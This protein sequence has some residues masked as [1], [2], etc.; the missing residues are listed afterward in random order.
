MA[1]EHPHR[2]RVMAIGLTLIVFSS[3]GSLVFFRTPRVLLT[4]DGKL[5]M[6]HPKAKT[7][8]ELLKEASVKLGP[9]DFVTPTAETALKRNLP[10]KVTRVLSRV[11][12]VEEP[13]PPRVRWSQRTRQ[14]LRRVLV[15]R[16]ETPIRVKKVRVKLHDG[17]EVSRET[18]SQTLK[19]R[20]FYTLSLFNDR[21][22]QIKTYDLL[23]AKTKTF[24]ATGYYVGD[25]MV[26][27]D[28][29]YLGYKLRRGFVAVDPE[30]IPL[31]WRLYIPSYGY[32]YSA[33]TGSAIKG[34][35]IDL[36]VKD[37]KEELIY[38]NK[39]VTIYLLEKAKK[40]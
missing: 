6:L 18:V 29:V 14:N 11:E 20:P 3:A 36:A 40:W 34:S 17:V 32:A 23:K 37:R 39:T 35:R 27:S 10:I 31:R 13:L 1:E 15:Q 22:F 7:V 26:P 9:E 25:P 28:T 21:G 4:V 30:T 8:G 24:L 33:D 38:N 16:G 12:T 2:R 5:Q 19:K